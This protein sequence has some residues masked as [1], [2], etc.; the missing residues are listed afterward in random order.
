[1]LVS[2][3]NLCRFWSPFLE[4]PPSNTGGSLFLPSAATEG[5]AAAG[6]T[7]TAAAVGVA[8]TDGLYQRPLKNLVAQKMYGVA[9]A[10]CISRTSIGGSTDVRSSFMRR[11]SRWFMLAGNRG[12]RPWGT[13][14]RF[15][16]FLVVA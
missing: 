16:Q 5:P 14:Y 2:C 13:V 12:L 1:M 15:A 10:A 11:S 9:S 7:G 8:A 3:R 6:V 4:S